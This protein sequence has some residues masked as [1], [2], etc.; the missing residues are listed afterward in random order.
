MDT[1]TVAIIR[2]SATISEL[3]D[4]FMVPEKLVF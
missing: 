2:K 4:M 3:T 1:C